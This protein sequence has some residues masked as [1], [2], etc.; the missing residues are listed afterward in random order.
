MPQIIY[1]ISAIFGTIFISGFIL[2]FSYKFTQIEK[3]C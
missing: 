2:Y 3:N 1:D